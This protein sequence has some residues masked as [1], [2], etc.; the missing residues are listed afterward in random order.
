MVGGLV[1]VLYPPRLRAVLHPPQRKG[2][3]AEGT[4]HGEYIGAL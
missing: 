1:Q 3:G 2:Q 4:S